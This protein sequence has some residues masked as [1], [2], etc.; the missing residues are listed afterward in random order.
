MTRATSEG[1]AG[2]RAAL[3]TKWIELV[4]AV[5]AYDMW[6]AHRG[7]EAVQ[8][9]KEERD[10][11]ELLYIEDAHVLD[12]LHSKWLTG[13][14]LVPAPDCPQSDR[15]A[16]TAIANF[17]GCFRMCLSCQAEARLALE[18]ILDGE[19]DRTQSRQFLEIVDRRS[20][21]LQRVS[22]RRDGLPTREEGLA[23]MK[24]LIASHLEPNVSR[25]PAPPKLDKDNGKWLSTAE[26]AKY[27]RISPKGLRNAKRQLRESPDGEYYDGTMGRQSRKDDRGRLYFFK[28]SL[29]AKQRARD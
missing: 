27:E 24:Q 23:R 21:Q 7:K 13:A 18:F 4:D 26:A 2:E 12:R 17:V 25:R 3:I 1:G 11:L 15:G 28:P 5:P 29:T 14:H 22:S 19:L 10:K 8:E 6:G 16:Q 20:R 9:R